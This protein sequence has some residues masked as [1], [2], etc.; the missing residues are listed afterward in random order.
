MFKGTVV[1]PKVNTCN[2]RAIDFFVV[3]EGLKQAAPMAYT[4]GDGG[5]YP[6][7]AVRLI[8]GVRLGRRS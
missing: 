6:R 2:S 8:S 1:A 4:I 3:S 7:S 5:F